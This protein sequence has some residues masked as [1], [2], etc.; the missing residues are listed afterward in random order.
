MVDT[1]TALQQTRGALSVMHYYNRGG[2][3][4]PRRS[5][6]SDMNR[7]RAA[8]SARWVAAELGLAEGVASAVAAELAAK[9]IEG[10]GLL[11]NMHQVQKVLAQH[12]V[13]HDAAEAVAA[14]CRACD[15]MAPSAA[16]AS[17][18]PTDDWARA[19]CRAG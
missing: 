17:P 5:R 12:L 2:D 13:G 6:S 7:W 1:R 15:N 3:D 16:F 11:G 18:R 14:L 10:D 19:S 9:D 8:E 4:R